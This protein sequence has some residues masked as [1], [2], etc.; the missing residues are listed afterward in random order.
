MAHYTIFD[1][2]RN[3]VQIQTFQ[4]FRRKYLC[5]NIPKIVEL[6]FT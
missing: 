3:N 5:K 6:D 1:L 4:I 2:L